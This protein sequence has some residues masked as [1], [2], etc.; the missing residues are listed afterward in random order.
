MV[1][2]RMGARKSSLQ[3]AQ[4]AAHL[5]KRHRMLATDGSE[6][7]QF[8]EI[9]ERETP[10]FA[11]CGADH[12][13]KCASSGAAAIPL[14]ERPSARGRRRQPQIPRS[15]SR[16]IYRCLTNIPSRSTRHQSPLLRGEHYTN[17]TCGCHRRRSSRHFRPNE[18]R[19]MPQTGTS[20]LTRLTQELRGQRKARQLA[21]ILGA[22]EQTFAGT[23]L[24]PSVQERAA[25]LFYS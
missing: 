22:I 7:E 20:P 15:L 6:N 18:S 21:G 17:G 10:R 23:R 8:N 25:H 19:F 24:Y 4:C 9:Q 2:Q 16:G 12:W 11:V 3:E 1:G 14:T 13:L 5:G